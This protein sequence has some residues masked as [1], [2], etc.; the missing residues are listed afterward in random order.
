M[1]LMVPAADLSSPTVHHPGAREQPPSTAEGL[2]AQRTVTPWVERNLEARK[3]QHPQDL[4]LQ[5]GQGCSGAVVGV[6]AGACPEPTA[7]DPTPS[8]TA[9]GLRAGAQVSPGLALLMWLTAHC[10]RPQAQGFSQGGLDASR[11]DLWASANASL[12]HS[13]WCQPASQLPR[14]QLSAL[15]RAMATRRV[16]LRAWQLSCLANLAALHG[17][18]DDFELHPPDLLLFYNLTQVR[19]A[20]C[21]AFTHRAAQGDTELLANLPDQRAALQRV[22]LACLGGPRLRLSASDLLLLGVLVCDMD[23]SSIVAADPRVLQNLQRCHRLTAPQ[24]AA[25]NTLLASGETTLGPPGSWNLEGLRAL[26]PLATYISSSL[27]MQV[28]QAVGLDF[29]GSTVATYRAGRL[30]QQDARR[31]VTGF[32]K[33]KAES[34]SSR[35]KRGTGRPCLRGDITAATLRDD[36]FLV[37]YD[38]V[39]LESCLGSR[40]L[41]ANLDPLLQHPLPAECQRVVKA[42]LARV[43]PRGVPEEQLPLIASLVYL[44][45]RSEIGQWNVTSRDTVVALLASDVALENQTEAV[46]QKYLDHNGTLTGALLVAIGGSRLC[47]MSARQIQAIRPSEF[48]LAGALD[49]SS[50]PQSRKDVLYAK[51]REAFGSTRTTAAYYR[52]MRPYLGG[53]P[54]EELRH[55]V[56][57]NVSMDIDTF[58]NLN[59]RVLQSLS[60]GNV[61]TLLGQNVGDLQKARSHPTISSWL[62]SL[63]R[64]ALG[65]LGLDTDP[66][67]LS[68]PGRSTTVTPNTAPRGPYPAPTS[69]LPR[70]SAPASGSPPAHLGYLPLSVALPSGLLWLLYWGT[71]GLSQDCSWDTR[72]MASEDG[73]APAPRAGKRGLVAGVHHVR[74]SRGPQGWS[75]PTSSSRDTELE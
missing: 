22:A 73:A 19:E 23:A 68:G 66:A 48:R 50:C 71:P 6:V 32:L 55:L 18:Q 3:R 14:D 33:A 5:A 31:F 28:Q 74:H 4:H 43:Y 30:S 2:R 21:R 46:L 60:V 11:A 29:F 47:W 51:A 44:Y 7:R 25:L 42:K 41:K 36:L 13:F 38:C 52:F 24:Q 65:E 1:D 26:G 8:C 67:G 56:Q 64:S 62:R 9:M 61:T 70:H 58:T 53:A 49:I 12:L 54:V 69:G 45:S 20:D 40:V 39:Q 59:P 34:V 27:W 57:A 63:N 35:P 15:I 75:P 17:L 37:H 72:T 16:L 10:S